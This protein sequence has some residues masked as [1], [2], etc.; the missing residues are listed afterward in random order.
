MRA[1]GWGGRRRA[2][3]TPSQQATRRTPPRTRNPSPSDGPPASTTASQTTAKHTHGPGTIPT[4]I[5]IHKQRVTTN[6]HLPD[7][8]I[9]HMRLMTPR[10]NIHHRH[11]AILPHLRKRRI[12]ERMP[13]IQLAAHILQPIR[14]R[15][16]QPNPPQRLLDDINLGQHPARLIIEPHG[17]PDEDLVTPHHQ[18]RATTSQGHL[19]LARHRQILPRQ[20][21]HDHRRRWPRIR[22]PTS[23]QH[24]RVTQMRHTLNTLTRKARLPILTTHQRMTMHLRDPIHHIRRHHLG[25]SRAELQNRRL[26]HP[27]RPHRTRRLINHHHMRLVID[28]VSSRQRDDPV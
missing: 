10:G 14:Q 5:A 17:L 13:D 23:Q 27:H 18:L 28:R 9:Q 19:K 8:L 4:H 26:S 3:V 20:Q 16:I 1:G 24:H 15:L 25:I 11:M 2:C 21:A 6:P 22:I 12:Q 7:P